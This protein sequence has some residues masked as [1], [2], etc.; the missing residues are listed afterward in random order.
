MNTQTPASQKAAAR[1]SALD[2]FFHVSAR[3]STFAREARG[4]A[5]TF[6]TMPAASFPFLFFHHFFF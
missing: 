5:A 3:G 6:F 4:G 2:A 1:G